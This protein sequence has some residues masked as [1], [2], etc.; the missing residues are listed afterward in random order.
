M[1]EHHI[2]L[3]ADGFPEITGMRYNGYRWVAEDSLDTE[4]AMLAHQQPGLDMF[5]GSGIRK[6]RRFEPRKP[7]SRRRGGF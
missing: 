7:K 3:D 5:G 4:R 2:I 6:P 1:A